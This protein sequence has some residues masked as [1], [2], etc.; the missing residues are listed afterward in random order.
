MIVVLVLA[1]LCSGLYAA[2]APGNID[3]HGLQLVLMLAALH[4]V[5]ERRPHL[6]AVAVA[7]GLGVG[8]ESLPYALAAI[9][10]WALDKDKARAFGITLAG[11][12]LVLLAATTADPYRLTP[13]CDTYSL[14]TAALLVV[15]GTGIAAISFLPRHRL[16]G[17]AVLALALLALAALLNPGLLW[18]VPMPGW[19]HA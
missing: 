14:F 11:M 8:L 6:G 2:F 16:A 12:A 15:G 7:L 17:L 9:G 4:G 3:H 10:F 5:I 18:Q 19:M 13:V 1:L